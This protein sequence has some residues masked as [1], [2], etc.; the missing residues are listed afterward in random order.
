MAAFAVR[1][2]GILVGLYFGLK[3][4]GATA[5]L[6]ALLGVGGVIGIAIGFAVR[7]TVDTYIS[8]IMLSVRQPFR[9]ND[10][11]VIEGN[12]GRVIRLTGRGPS[13]CRWTATTCAFPAAPCSRR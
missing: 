12:Q 10:H 11:V 3:I 4:L 2:V 5:L 9:A 13:W 8:S 1:F 6:G 7:D